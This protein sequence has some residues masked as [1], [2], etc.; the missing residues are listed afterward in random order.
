[1][2][3]LRPS[4]AASHQQHAN[5]CLN[6]CRCLV[7][8]CGKG[9]TTRPRARCPIQQQQGSSSKSPGPIRLQLSCLQ[10]S[11]QGFAPHLGSWADDA[12]NAEVE[13]GSDHASVPADLLLAQLKKDTTPSI[14]PT[15]TSDKEP[16]PGAQAEDL[17]WR[18]D[19]SADQ[20]NQSNARG[21][22][23]GGGAKGGSHALGTSHPSLRTAQEPEGGVEE[24]ED[25]YED[26]DAAW[27]GTNSTAGSRSFHHGSLA[28]GE[29][30][31]RRQFGAADGAAA[32]AAGDSCNAAWVPRHRRAL[33]VLCRAAFPGNRP[34]QRLRRAAALTLAT[35]ARKLLA[36]LPGT[37]APRVAPTVSLMVSMH[38]RTHGCQTALDSLRCSWAQHVGFGQPGTF[39]P[40]E[41]C[42]CMGTL[43]ITACG[44]EACTAAQCLTSTVKYY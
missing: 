37:Q 44:C 42:M 6:A 7:G 23:S 21:L 16:P 3:H 24:V 19:G 25:A 38:A 17:S 35:A 27:E 4:A 5:W 22:S 33:H 43:S 29:F 28:A 14:S 11:K 30:I 8:L 34:E 2:C 39:T 31:P 15:S 26:C 9:S 32:G 40:V 13:A 18:T 41:T 12:E 1:M 10:M 36:P 20:P